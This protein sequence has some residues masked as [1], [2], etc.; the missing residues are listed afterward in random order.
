[1]VKNNIVKLDLGIIENEAS[2]FSEVSRGFISLNG[3]DFEVEFKEHYQEMEIQDLLQD[4]ISFIEE[5]TKVEEKTTVDLLTFTQPYITTLIIKHFTSMKMPEDIYET[6]AVTKNMINLGVLEQFIRLFPQD[7]LTKLMERVA[8][9]LNATSDAMNELSDESDRI[10]SGKMKAE[11]KMKANVKEE[12]MDKIKVSNQLI[13]E[14][15]SNARK[16]KPDVE[17]GKK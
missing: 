2:K 1:M 11:T 12:T 4:L 15:L 10:K 5:S 8:E 14:A 17:N 16:E 3:K 13:D 9:A 6:I 7:Q